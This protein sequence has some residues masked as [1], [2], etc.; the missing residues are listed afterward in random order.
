[1]ATGMLHA[2]CGWICDMIVRVC[3][4]V[5]RQ[6]RNENRRGLLVVEEEGMVHAQKNT[7]W[8]E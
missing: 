2:H 8:K 6:C 3:L 7:H 4:V 1:M 5:N